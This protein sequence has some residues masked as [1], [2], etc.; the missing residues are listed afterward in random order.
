[1]KLNS[2]LLLAVSLSSG[3][4]S[5]A[6]QLAAPV[7]TLSLTGSSSLAAVCGFLVYL[8]S[9][10]GPMLG[11][12]VDRTH[13]QRLLITAN[14]TL[15][16]IYLALFAVGTRR[17]LWILFAVMLCKGIVHVL[18]DSGESALLP[19]ALPA[20]EIPKLNGLRMS[21]REGMKLVAP[22]TGAGL[23]T[24]WG[25]HAVAALSMVALGISAILYALVRPHREPVAAARGKARDGMRFLLR[26]QDLRRLVL[27][28][29]LAASM[30][31]FATASVYSMITID[32]GLDPAFLGVLGSAQGA[33]S[34]IGGILAGRMSVHFGPLGAALFGTGMAMWFLPSVPLMVAGSVIA[35]IGLPWTVVAAMSAVQLWTPH[36]M[37]GR[38]SASASTIIFAPIA[39]A[40]PAGA[41]FGEWAG[42]HTTRVLCIAAV[43]SAASLVE[44]KRRLSQGEAPHR[45]PSSDLL[46]GEPGEP[47]A[48][49]PRNA[50][51]PNRQAGAEKRTASTPLP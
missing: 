42:Y 27:I 7:W 43:I 47:A 10:A 44:V 8:P 20:E 12:I 11:T 16:V 32:H 21:A 25:G 49:Y 30:S 3:F 28:S 6:M 22:L 48:G 24:L 9:L 46:P 34:I 5:N 29:A 51:M 37:L 15:A 38:V 31:G 41:A 45:S 39:I 40:I 50:L 4:G 33:G 14:L 1:M 2:H 17:Q 13:R 35:G 18:N 23:F 26:H 19:A 36:E